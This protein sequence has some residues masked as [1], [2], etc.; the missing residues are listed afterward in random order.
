MDL[1]REKNE[2]VNEKDTLNNPEINQKAEGKIFEGLDQSHIK[3]DFLRVF[4][5]DSPNQLIE[6]VTHEYM[7]R[8]EFSGI[9]D[10]GT[11]KIWYYPDA[12]KALELKSLKYYI[13]SYINILI[14]QEKSLKR[15]YK[16]LKDIL[17]TERLKV[18]LVYRTRGGFDVTCSEGSLEKKTKK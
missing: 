1:G 5:F 17:K 18:D 8:C 3:T 4:N 14:F 2:G 15:I 12:G 10:Y 13:I 6:I 7:S 9:P 11:L 16:D